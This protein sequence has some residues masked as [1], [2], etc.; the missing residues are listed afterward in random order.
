MKLVDCNLSDNWRLIALDPCEPSP[1]EN[2]LGG[3]IATDDESRTFFIHGVF[4]VMHGLDNIVKSCQSYI[5]KHETPRETR[6]QV[7]HSDVKNRLLR[8]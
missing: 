5:D 4:L 6:R 7:L 8:V 3:E 1:M 2:H